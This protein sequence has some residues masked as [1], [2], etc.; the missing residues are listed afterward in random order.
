MILLRGAGPAAIG[1]IV[2][3]LL[4]AGI[5]GLATVGVLGP[6]VGLTREHGPT[7]GGRARI[8]LERDKALTL[9][10]IKELEFD[11]A[12]GKVS[13]ADFIEMRERLRQRA[14]RLMRQLEGG[15]AYRQLIEQRGRRARGRGRERPA[16]PSAPGRCAQCDTAND[17]DARFCK[18]CGHRLEVAT[19]GAGVTPPRFAAVTVVALLLAIPA[20]AQMPDPRIMSG[21]II[22]SPDLP[23][24]TVTVRVIRQTIMNVAPGIDVELHGAGDVRHATTGAEGRAEFP[25]L[26]AGAHV[27]AVAVVDGE[28]LRS[29]EFDVPA[30]GGVRTMLA[31]GVGVGEMVNGGTAP[32]AAAPAAPVAPAP[33]AK[34]GQLAF[35]NDTRFAVEFQDD[36]LAVFYLLDI[37]NPSSGPVALS[38]PLVI[39]LPAGASGAGFWRAGRRWPRS[40]DAASPSPAPLPSGVTTVPVAYRIESWAWRPGR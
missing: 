23:A 15:G 3:S 36:T 35:A 5:V 17:V 33:P 6:L 26:P 29:I 14:L 7:I 8:A 1:V 30:A 12:M 38:E 31:A 27:H 11:R 24:G 22:P 18:A 20:A 2:F 28:R 13:D 40:R 25:G 9:R 19:G 32:S 10:A 4:A 21:Q 39:D 34:P 16:L 37:V